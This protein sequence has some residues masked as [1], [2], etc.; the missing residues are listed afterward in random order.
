LAA[1]IA[2]LL[3]GV[4]AYVLGRI[5]TAHAVARHRISTSSAD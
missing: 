2:I 1:L 4:V 5:R 3:L